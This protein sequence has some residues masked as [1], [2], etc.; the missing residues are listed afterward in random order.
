MI[1]F[2]ERSTFER[3]LSQFARRYQIQIRVSNQRQAVYDNYNP[4]T[5]M[6]AQI[7]HRDMYELTISERDIEHLM[8]VDNEWRSIQEAAKR[9]PGVRDA[10]EQLYTIYHMSKQTYE[11]Y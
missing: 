5:S 9:N 10:L 11:Q 8:K 7:H 4:F 2:G 6:D 1:S 3:Q